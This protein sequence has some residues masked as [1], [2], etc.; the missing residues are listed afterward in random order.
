VSLFFRKSEGEITHGQRTIYYTRKKGK[1]DHWEKEEQNVKEGNFLDINQKDPAR[2]SRG[3]RSEVWSRSEGQEL[4]EETR[5]AK[6]LVK[7]GGKGGK[8]TASL[9]RQH[10]SCVL[11]GKKLHDTGKRRTQ[12]GGGGKKVGEARKMTLPAEERNQTCLFLL[13]ASL[14][15]TK[16]EKN[17]E[18]GLGVDR[19]PQKKYPSSSPKKPGE[20]GQKNRNGWDLEEKR[21]GLEHEGERGSPSEKG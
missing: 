17:R 4:E 18:E 7:A 5:W 6:N 8:E 15:A 20:G 16:E 3:R 9:W 2:L 1:G 12:R 11:R 21:E 14:R 13:P 19:A 10:P